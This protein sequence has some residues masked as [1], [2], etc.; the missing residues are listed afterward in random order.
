MVFTLGSTFLVLLAL[1]FEILS[2]CGKMDTSRF[3]A[4]LPLLPLVIYALFIFIDSARHN[5]SPKIGA[6][7]ILAAFIQLFGYG[8][9]FLEAWWKRCI[10]GHDEFSAFNKT[11][12]K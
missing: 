2:S 1:L 3:I 9:G 10:L 6:L 11:F 5:K 7:S 8:I 12:Y 4:I